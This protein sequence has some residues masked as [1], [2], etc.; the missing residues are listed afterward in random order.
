MTEENAKE[1]AQPPQEQEEGQPKEEAKKTVTKEELEERE[2]LIAK[3][4]DLNSRQDALNARDKM[5]GQ[6]E[7][8]KP[9][10]K[11]EVLSDKEYAEALERGEVNPMKEDGFK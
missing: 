10:V 8:G 7:A 6:S 1:E 4:E 9:A 3:Q 2:A 5:G 11:K